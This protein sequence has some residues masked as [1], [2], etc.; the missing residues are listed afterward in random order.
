MEE[1]EE[2]SSEGFGEYDQKEEQPFTGTVTD[3]NKPKALLQ[4]YHEKKIQEEAAEQREREF[5]ESRIRTIVLSHPKIEIGKPSALQEKLSEMTIAQLR[6]TLR[7]AEDQIG[8]GSYGTEKAVLHLLDYALQTTLGK[9]F[10][11]EVYEDCRLLTSIQRVMPAMSSYLQDPL[12]AAVTVLQSI[13]NL[14]QDIAP[15]SVE[16]IVLSDVNKKTDSVYVY[17]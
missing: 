11:P 8:V 2:D 5:I 6:Y 9:T 14:S 12:H 3:L 4:E 16:T 7:S 1:Y 13:V 17:F 15:L 10:N